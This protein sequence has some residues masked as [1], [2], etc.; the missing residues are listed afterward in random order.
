MANNLSSPTVKFCLSKKLA[1]N[2]QESNIPYN[3]AI[4]PDTTCLMDIIKEKKTWSNDKKHPT[5]C[6]TSLTFSV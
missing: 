3:I 4:N 5:F 6:Q 2:K 1:A